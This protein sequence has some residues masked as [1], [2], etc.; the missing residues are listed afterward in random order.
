M[1]NLE[2]RCGKYTGQTGKLLDYSVM[3]GNT[4]TTSDIKTPPAGEVL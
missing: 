2:K 3:D 1:V 4:T